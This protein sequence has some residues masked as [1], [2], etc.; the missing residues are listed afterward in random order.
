MISHTVA[1]SRAIRRPDHD[2]L[3]HRASL[4]LIGGASLAGWGGIIL[5]L[6]WLI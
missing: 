5:L 2:R 6:Q 3:S 1:K 4:L